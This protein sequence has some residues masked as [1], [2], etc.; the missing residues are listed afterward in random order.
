MWIQRATNQSKPSMSGIPCTFGR[1][2][3][4]S[5]NHVVCI[6]ALP[7]IQSKE[8]AEVGKLEKTDIPQ[9]CI[10]SLVEQ[11]ASFGER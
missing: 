11:R 6:T 10:E 8:L 5:Q 1:H 7:C 4:A 9:I 3:R 2:G